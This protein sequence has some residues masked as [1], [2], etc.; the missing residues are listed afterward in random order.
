MSLRTRL[1]KCWPKM[2]SLNRFD[3]AVVEESI[4][5]SIASLNETRA[6]YEH[7]S[8]AIIQSEAWTMDNE[9]LTPTLK[10]KRFNLDSAFGEQYLN[11]H[12]NPDKVIW[13]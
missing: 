4:V 10:V 2:I 8:T 7:I 13:C 3:K 5:S 11:W 12:E 9:F 1:K 6:K